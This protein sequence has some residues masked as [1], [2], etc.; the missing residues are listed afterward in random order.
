MERLALPSAHMRGDRVA[1]F[2]LLAA[3]ALVACTC[4]A[5]VLFQFHALRTALQHNLEVQAAMLAPAAVEALRLQDR[6]AAD[7]VLAPL[8]AAP[9]IEQALLYT[10]YGTPFAR[11]A[12]NAGDSAP[13]A[14]VNGD[15]KS[16]V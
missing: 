13:A 16:V 6:A 2:N 15:R 3:T 10:P 12:R 4:L 8:A 11:F 5:L 14:P 1:R 7:Q 9:T